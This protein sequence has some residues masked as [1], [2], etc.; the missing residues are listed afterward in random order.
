MIVVGGEGVAEDVNGEGKD[1]EARDNEKHPLQL[2]VRLQV[3]FRRQL[4]CALQHYGQLEPVHA[5]GEE[6][7]FEE[8]F[9]RLDE[10]LKL[11]VIR[12]ALSLT[13][14][15]VGASNE[16]VRV[17]DC[18]QADAKQHPDHQ[19]QHAVPL[20]QI[21]LA[22]LLHEVDA[23]EGKYEREIVDDRCV[24]ARECVCEGHL[25]HF[26]AS[27]PQYFGGGDLPH[28]LIIILNKIIV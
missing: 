26:Q 4:A 10:D 16:Q 28:L 14:D 22:L 12:D 17:V 18:E 19:Q 8:D 13:L 2:F 6:W 5:D 9:G 11:E 20:E 27:Y 1:D 25:F 7:E 15:E 23:R 3:G 24:A 21:E